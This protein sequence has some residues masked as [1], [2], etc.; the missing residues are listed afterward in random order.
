MRRLI[1]RA[2]LA[3][4]LGLAF[5]PTL[6]GGKDWLFESLALV[7]LIVVGLSDPYGRY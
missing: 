7:G 4:T 3:A 2:L 6:I 5:L 1:R